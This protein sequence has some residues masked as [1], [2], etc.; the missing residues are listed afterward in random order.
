MKKFLVVVLVALLLGACG[1]TETKEPKSVDSSEK[2]KNETNKE[3]TKK[4]EPKK[5]NQEIA[6]TENI[7]ATLI[8]VEKKEDDVFG[9]T[10]EVMFEVE[11]KRDDTIEIQ[12]REVSADGKMVDEGMLSMS[13]EI[14]GGK[15]ADATLT[16]QNYDDGKEIPELKENLEMIL[17]AFSWDNMDFEEEHNVK[18][19]F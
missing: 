12:A 19:D 10:I 16:I 9:D 14:S 8:S 2:S 15:K 17:Y 13:Q 5:L 1:A 4:E 6:D 7:K 3:E 11:N 18:I